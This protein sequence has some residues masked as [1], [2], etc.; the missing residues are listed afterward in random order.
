V[1][2][3]GARE[4]TAAAVRGFVLEEVAAMVLIA[5]VAALPVA[6]A[7]ACLRVSVAVVCLA[8]AHIAFLC[9]VRPHASGID[10]GFAV[11]NAASLA[12]LGCVGVYSSRRESSGEHGTAVPAAAASFADYIVFAQTAAFVIQP[13]VHLALM[14]QRQWCSDGNNEVHEAQASHEAAAAAGSQHSSPLLVVPPSSRDEFTHTAA[15]NPLLTS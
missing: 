14:A 13:V 6:D 2:V 3:D 15:K 5:A 11:G 8:L 7:D 10:L 12:A 9:A 1:F 4:S